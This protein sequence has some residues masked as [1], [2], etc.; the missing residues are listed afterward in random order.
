MELEQYFEDDK[1]LG[2]MAT[3]DGNGEVNTA[4]YARPH[5][6]NGYALFVMREKK[7]H[8]NI[9]E[10]PAANYLYVADNKTFTGIRMYLTFQNDTDDPAK[11]EKYR[12]RNSPVD[13]AL[14]KERLHLVSFKID[15]VLSLVG[16]H[17][18]EF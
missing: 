7:T 13:E 1:G 17:E 15:K 6:E 3:A 11:V 9:R 2:V 8:A 12:R 14:D 16:D 5:I 10:N 4:I 18:I